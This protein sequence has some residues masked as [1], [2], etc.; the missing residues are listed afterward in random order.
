MIQLPWQLARRGMT[1]DAVRVADAFA[2][3]DRDQRPLYASDA[4]V[5]LAEAGRAPGADPPACSR[6][7]SSAIG[8]ST[9]GR[10][11]RPQIVPCEHQALATERLPTP[12]RQKRLSP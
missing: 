4:A 11:A 10:A 5:I 2:E 1:E 6:P 9:P 8:L 12:R 3:F 7:L